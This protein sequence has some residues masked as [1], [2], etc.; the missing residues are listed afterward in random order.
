MKVVLL[1]SGVTDQIEEQFEERALVLVGGGVFG[2][3]TVEDGENGVE[4]VLEEDVGVVAS[5]QL[6]GDDYQLGVVL[7]V[8][9]VEG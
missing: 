1:A 2:K 6:V 4:G 3:G 8:G 7:D 9:G 5:N